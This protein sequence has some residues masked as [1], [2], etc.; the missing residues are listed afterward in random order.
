VD[1][2][3]LISYRDVTNIA[4]KVAHCRD[5]V[6]TSAALA[7]LDSAG[8]VGLNTSITIGTDGLGLIS[9]RD[10]TNGDLKVAHCASPLCTAFAR[11]R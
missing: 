5:V 4:L 2:L 7:T 6:C 8:D 3:G 1:G 9:Y 11:R 10:N